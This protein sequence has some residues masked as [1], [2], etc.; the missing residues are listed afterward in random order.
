MTVHPRDR[1]LVVLH[2]HAASA[3]SA[4]DLADRVDPA[5]SWIH[6]TPNG[7]VVESDGSRSWFTADPDRPDDISAAGRLVSSLID[8]VAVDGGIA[9]TRIAVVGWS[10]G[11]AATLAALAGPGSVRVG[12]LVLASAFLAEG[13]IDYD[14]GRLAKVPVLVQHGRDDEVVPT[15]FADDLSAALRSAGVDVDDR[16][17]A[18]G[19]ARTAEADEDARRWLEARIS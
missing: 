13:E 5:G 12:A 19:H 9:P 16:R 10:Q 11:G 4:A 17:Y 3:G 8:A 2:G 14:L 1:A 15:F 18:V 6:L 7:P